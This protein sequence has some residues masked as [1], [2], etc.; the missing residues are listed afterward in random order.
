MVRIVLVPAVD[1]MEH[2]LTF[3]VL[4]RDVFAGV[5]CLRRVGRVHLQQEAAGKLGLIFQQ[6]PDTA[7]ARGS[8]RPVE[9]TLRRTPIR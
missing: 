9:A 7:H 3:T 5:A 1:A 2:R 4:L 8:H 6:E